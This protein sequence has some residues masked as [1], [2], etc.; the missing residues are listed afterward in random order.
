MCN[1]ATQ[2]ICQNFLAAFGLFNWSLL[3]FIGSEFGLF[4]LFGNWDHNDSPKKNPTDLVFLETTWCFLKGGQLESGTVLSQYLA[5]VVALHF[6]VLLH[7]L[8]LQIVVLHWCALFYCMPFM[9]DYI[10]FDGG[11]IT[12]FYLRMKRWFQKIQDCAQFNTYHT[13]GG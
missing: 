5:A 1:S 2:V 3:T 10:P 7:L 13:Y 12:F 8:Q 6:K 9:W 4:G 11:N